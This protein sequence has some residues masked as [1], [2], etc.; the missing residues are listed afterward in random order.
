[1]LTYEESKVLSYLRKRVLSRTQDLARACLPGATP[2]WVGRVLA[3]LEWLGYI[4]VFSDPKG[5]PH[6]VQPTEEGLRCPV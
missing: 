3:D 6:A 5:R 1:M 2:E 4:V